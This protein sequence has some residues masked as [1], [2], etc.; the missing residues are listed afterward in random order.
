MIV[1]GRVSPSAIPTISPYTAP[2]YWME[3]PSLSPG[4][5]GGESKRNLPSSSVTVCISFSGPALLTRNTGRPGPTWPP[6]V[7]SSTVPS[8]AT[9]DAS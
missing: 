3:T 1:M 6:A 7:P 4:G 5:A 2:W 9:V 8:T